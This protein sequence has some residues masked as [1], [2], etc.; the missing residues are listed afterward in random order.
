MAEIRRCVVDNLTTRSLGAGLGLLGKNSKRAQKQSRAE[1]RSCL[2][3]AEQKAQ[4]AKRLSKAVLE[5]Q[6][7]GP[8][9][10]PT[11]NDRLSVKLIGT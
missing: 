1:F 3:S 5:N 7:S 2:L 10:D 11:K 9:D 6:V 4:I 8:S